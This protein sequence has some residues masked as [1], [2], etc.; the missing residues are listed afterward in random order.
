MRRSVYS[1]IGAALLIACATQMSGCI[2]G[3][4]RV[5]HHTGPASL[6]RSTTTTTTTVVRPVVAPVIHRKRQFHYYPNAQV[7][8]D[9]E[10]N[11]WFWR[12][13]ETWKFGAQAP[14]SFSM[15]IEIPVAIE[16]EADQPNEHH[17]TIVKNY[18]PRPDRHNNA[19]D[20]RKDRRDDK[21]NDRDDRRKDR[22]D[23][24]DKN[25]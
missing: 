20:D 13:G 24:K 9:C 16:L 1:S 17:V 3:T 12:E 22:K 8:K 5:V 18:P 19:N 10:S 21:K 15:D 23:R 7:Y 25:D 4:E 2:I 6:P 14:T 11:R